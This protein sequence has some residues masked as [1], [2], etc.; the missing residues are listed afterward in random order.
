MNLM[1]FWQPAGTYEKV[2]G[3]IATLYGGGA[4]DKVKSTLAKLW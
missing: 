3:M 4:V 1:S 2:R